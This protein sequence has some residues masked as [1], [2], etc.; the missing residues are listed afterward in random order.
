[1]WD[2]APVAKHLL[3]LNSLRSIPKY[4]THTKDTI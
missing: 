1:V 4:H 3:L 2:M